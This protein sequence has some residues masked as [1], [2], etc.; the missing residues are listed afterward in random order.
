MP[1]DID[2]CLEELLKDPQAESSVVITPAHQHPMKALKIKEDSTTGKKLVSY[3]SESGQ[4]VTPIA[5]QSYEKAYFRANIIISKIETIYKY[6][7]SKSLT[8]DNVRYHIIPQE[9]A[10]DI[11]SEAD[12][13]IAELL[14]KKFKPSAINSQF[15]HI[16]KERIDQTLAAQTKKGTNL[17]EPLKSLATEK[18][19]PFKILEDNQVENDAEVH[20][21]VGDLWYCMEG[22]TEFT[23]GGELFKPTPLIKSGNEVVGEL[24][25]KEITGGQKVILKPGDWLWIPPGTPHQHKCDNIARM[26]IIKI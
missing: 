9:R 18:K 14:L 26:I 21:N 4:E 16:K 10:T 20:A 19:L 6:Q 15:E 25:S 1:E 11:D 3:F 22:E 17:L 5:R 7:D 8:G 2:L 13:Q 12:F 24:R 23:C